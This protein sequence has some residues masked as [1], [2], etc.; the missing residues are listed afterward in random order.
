VAGPTS[1]VRISHPDRRRTGRPHLGGHIITIDNV[2]ARLLDPTTA[3]RAAQLPR[4]ITEDTPDDV[5]ARADNDLANRRILLNDADAADVT[6]YHADPNNEPI[7]P[8]V[9][10]TET[11][12]ADQTPRLVATTQSGHLL[13]LT[14][15]VL[16]PW[17]AGSTLDVDV[18]ADGTTTV[19]TEHP[20]DADFLKQGPRLAVLDQ[21][22]V[23]DLLDVLIEARAGQ[24]APDVSGLTLVPSVATEP[25]SQA[26]TPAP[27]LPVPVVDEPEPTPE[28]PTVEEPAAEKPPPVSVPA[29]GGPPRRTRADPTETPGTKAVAHVLGS[30]ALL[31][32]DDT[33]GLATG[34]RPRALVYLAAHREGAPLDD[35]KEG[36]YPDATI[37]CATQRLATDVA[38]LRHR[39]RHIL[40]AAGDRADPVINTGGRYHLNS[41]LVDVDWWTVHDLATSAKHSEDNDERIRFLHKAIEAYHAILADGAPYEWLSSHQRSRPSAVPPLNRSIIAVS[42]I[43]GQRRS[44]T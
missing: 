15:V 26:T 32:P 42:M 27:T 43:P 34:G 1:R 16:G 30:P 20:D 44:R 12:D 2:L 31:Y 40:G 6:A 13:D 35:I 23:R 28:R 24:V 33:R 41:D 17:P 18:D 39:I 11:P 37:H 8:V 3:G 10:I 7:P 25:D 5:L 36:L 19:A 9:V 14:V 22:A 38:N 4:L 29:R 21:S